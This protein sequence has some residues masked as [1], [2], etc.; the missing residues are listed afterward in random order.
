MCIETGGWKVIVLK[1]VENCQPQK[2]FPNLWSFSAV[3]YTSAFGHGRTTQRTNCFISCMLNLH[4][5]CEITVQK[6]T[7]QSESQLGGCQFQQ[8]VATG[9]THSYITGCQPM[10]ALCTS[11]TMIVINNTHTSRMTLTPSQTTQ[12]YIR[13]PTN[14]SPACYSIPWASML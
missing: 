6:D 3:I 2:S 7:D 10:W 13:L 12:K 4:K 8:I 9:I 1:S 5:S 14:N 11:N